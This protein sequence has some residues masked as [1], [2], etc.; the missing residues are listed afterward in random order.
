MNE[1]C[2]LA[3]D[4]DTPSLLC[5][6]L[7]DSETNNAQETTSGRRGEG[8][9]EAS[10]QRGNEEAREET[11]RE[12]T[13]GG[14]EKRG[15][16][17]V[18]SE[19]EPTVRGDGEAEAC[20]VAAADRKETKVTK[21][22]EPKKSRKRRGKKQNEQVRSRRAGNRKEEE[23][24]E[25]GQAQDASAVPS[26]ENPAL[27]EPSISL[28]SHCDLSDQVYLGFEEAGMYCPPVP[29]PLLYSSQPPVPIQ[30]DPP[31]SHRTKRPRSPPPPHGLPQQSSQALEM[32]ITQVYSTRR[33]VRYSSRGRG[34]PLGFPLLPGSENVDGCPLPPAPKKKTR[35]LYTSDQLEHLEALFQEDHY[36]DAEKRKLIAASVGVT[37]QR[38]MV[39]FQNR[40]AKWRKVRSITAKAESTQ[41]VSSP[42]LKINPALNALTSNRK[43]APSF[44]GHFAAA[45]PQLATAASFPSQTPPSFSSLL[46][47]LSSPGQCRGTDVGQHQLSAQGSLPEFHPRPM[48]SPPPLRR[49]SLPLFTTAYNPVSPN[50]PLLNTP[51]HTPPLFL[52]ALEGVSSLAHCDSQSL[53]TDSSSL[54][55]FPEKLNYQ[56]SGQQS[57]SLSYQ[58]SYP[59]SQQQTS[60]PHMTYLTPSPYLTPNPPDSN[61]TSY[62]TFGPGGSSAGV[63]TYSA[64]GQTYFPPQ[65]AGQIL[66][67]SAG[68]NGGMPAYPSY[69]W[70]NLYSQT[71]A[72]QRA[73]P[74]Y[75]TS[76]GSSRDH[77]TPST[78]SLPLPSFFP[79]GEHGS[80]H[81]NLQHSSNAQTHTKTSSSAAT[82]T[83][84]V[85]P[86]VSTLRAPCLRAETTP[87]KVS[88][89]LSS[90]QVSS[91][92]PESPPVPPCVK[93]EYDSP[94]EIHS[95][96]HCDFSPIHF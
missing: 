35:T 51:V 44:S 47:S 72:N 56:T 29:V 50:P 48:H 95:H 30:P 6:E 7:E 93:L 91:P 76:L 71:A 25:R 88:S 31:P 46:D 60:L 74:T 4:F 62:L 32:E 45:L 92:S 33:S 3:E 73:P 18:A 69:P 16:E 24:E 49:A 28:L 43:G 21:K 27:L 36:P 81:V 40:R 84:T 10:N 80:S 52:D 66:L 20:R 5:E 15:D 82:A 67:Q 41:S 70:G 11:E 83:A 63:V 22:T 37:P 23:E 14:E 17:V 75:P 90:P 34:Q 86:P 61:P 39:W 57:G 12:G 89:L 87:N 65:S 79:Q 54:F 58:I 64:G 53:Q 8:D 68:H 85:L 94:R 1:D 42:T 13:N 77:Q 9:E 26:E 59:A 55:D 96:F 38:I 19:K 78:S 2:N